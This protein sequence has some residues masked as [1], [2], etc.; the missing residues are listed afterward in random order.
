MS[1][2]VKLAAG[3][4]LPQ[5]PAQL[6][7]S[8]EGLLVWLKQNPSPSRLHH[9]LVSA[10]QGPAGLWVCP[11]GQAREQ[12]VCFPR[13]RKANGKEWSP[14]G[15]RETSV[16]SEAL[17]SPPPLPYST[18]RLWASPAGIRKR[19]R[20]HS[21]SPVPRQQQRVSVRFVPGL[22]TGIPKHGWS[23][24]GLGPR[25]LAVTGSFQYGP[26]SGLHSQALGFSGPKKRLGSTGQDHVSH[27]SGSRRDVLSCPLLLLLS[28]VRLKCPLMLC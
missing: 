3:P 18:L 1:L 9:F 6:P 19:R 16:P 17:Q 11:F 4:F 13:E 12:E 23:Q 26:L 5:G 15:Q 28:P 2:R 25:A 21:R 22:P 7:G 8:S 10:E 14:P 20:S 27:H 24:A